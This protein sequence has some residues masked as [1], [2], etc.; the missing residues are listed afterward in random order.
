VVQTS[1]G[2]VA[3]AR[4]LVELFEDDRAR[5]WPAG[6]RAGS[7]LRIH[8]ALKARP[9]LTLQE[10]ARRAGLSFPS[11][12]AGMSV[13]A[14]LGIGRELTGKRRNRVFVYDRYLATLSRGTET[15]RGE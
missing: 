1:D 11:A 8:D 5:I 14:D 7:A 13:L 12:A 10:A 9:L 4:R 6:R 3:T 2:A 15:G